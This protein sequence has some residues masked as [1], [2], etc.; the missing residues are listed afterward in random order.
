M[1]FNKSEIK[2]PAMKRFARPS[3]SISK[4]CAN[5]NTRPSYQFNPKPCSFIFPKKKQT[6]KNNLFCILSILNR[7]QLETTVGEEKK[8][9]PRLTKDID[10]FVEIMNN[11]NLPKPKMI[12]K[13]NSEPVVLPFIRHFVLSMAQKDL[14]S[15]PH[16]G[17]V[18]RLETPLLR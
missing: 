5:P 6:S 7:G 11:L 18:F 4:S 12:G 8:Y 1:S 9:N 17:N 14:N 16:P 2:W 15:E 13:Y 3:I 10:S